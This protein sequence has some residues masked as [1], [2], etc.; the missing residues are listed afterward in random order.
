M[1]EN[2]STYILSKRLV[3]KIYKEQKKKI[4]KKKKT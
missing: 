1:R 4:G 2:L 3:S